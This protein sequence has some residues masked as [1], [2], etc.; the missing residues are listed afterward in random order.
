LNI[1]WNPEEVGFNASKGTNLLAR[2]EQA[3]KEQKLYSFIQLC[4]L[5]A[6]DMA[7]FVVSSYIKI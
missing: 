4:R 7:Q 2:Q 3:G 5:P 1:C 6:E